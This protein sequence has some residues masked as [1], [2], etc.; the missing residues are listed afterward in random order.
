VRLGAGTLYGSI[1][2]MLTDGLIEESA[3]RARSR[4]PGG[5]MPGM[6][7]NR[8]ASISG[9]VYTALLVAY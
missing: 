5:V 6:A 3:G 1:T 2:R 9:R 8:V 4:F 7:S